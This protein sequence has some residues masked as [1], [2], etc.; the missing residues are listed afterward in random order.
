MPRRIASRSVQCF[1]DRSNGFPA[2]RASG[3]GALELG[4][5]VAEKIAVACVP[6]PH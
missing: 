3:V 1:A 6:K 2:E 4:Y 5:R